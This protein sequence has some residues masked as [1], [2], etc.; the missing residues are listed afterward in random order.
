MHNPKLILEMHKLFWDFK[1]QM[2]HLILA[3]QPDP[4]IIKKRKQAEL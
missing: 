4:V 1:I 2:D 3:R